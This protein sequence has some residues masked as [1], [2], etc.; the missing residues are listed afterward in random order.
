MPNITYDADTDFG[1]IK[2]P[3]HNA[4]HT[5][6]GTPAIVGVQ[7]IQF[8]H[9][10]TSENGINGIQNEDLLK[11]LILRLRALNASWPCRENG[12]AITKTEEVLH[13]LEHRT[14]LRR[15]QGV[16]GKNEPHIS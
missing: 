6:D 2:I 15:E 7:N 9:G 12:L 4:P 11:L 8:Q 16:E 13:W 3:A 10:P 1:T 14:A 5:P